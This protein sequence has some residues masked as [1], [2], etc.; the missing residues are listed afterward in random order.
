MGYKLLGVA[1][2]R[3]AKWYLRRRYG[4]T[5][6]KVAAGVVVAGALAAGLAAAARQTRGSN[7]S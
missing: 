2:W 6:R 3:G 1:V 4:G 5:P 7:G